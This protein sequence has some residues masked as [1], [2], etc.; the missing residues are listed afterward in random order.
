[1]QAHFMRFLRHAMA[2]SVFVAA[3]SIAGI[4]HAAPYAAMVMD[5][6]NGEVIFARNHDTKLHP[7]SLTKMMTLYVAFEAIK[8]GEVTLDSQFTVSRNATQTSCVCLGLRPG[9]QISLRYLIRAAALRSAN[10]ASVVIAEGIS[11]SVEAFAERMTRTARAMGMANT[12]FRNPHG[13]TQTGHLSTARD[14]TILGRQLYF[15]YPQYFNIF[16]RRSDFAGVGNVPNT[17][18]RFLDAYSGADG[19]KTGYTR[20]AGF[21][22][23]ASAKRGGKHIISTMFGGSSAAARNAHV[24]ELMDIGF[25]RAATRVATRAPGTPAYQG[26]AA[27]AVAQ[28]PARNGDDDPGAA[29]K[30]I[31]LQTAVRVSQRPQQRPVRAP[32]DAILLAVRESVDAAVTD[33]TTIAE[34]EAVA[35]EVG[36][37]EIAVL[38]PDALGVTPPPRPDLSEADD[39]A[40]VSLDAAV[41]AGFSIAAPEDVAELASNDGPASEES[42]AS[43]DLAPETA[44]EE[45]VQMA[46]LA[47]NPTQERAPEPEQ[48]AESVQLA[49]AQG[50]P[51]DAIELVEDSEITWIGASESLLAE[52]ESDD[53]L[54]EGLEEPVQFASL[55]QNAAPPASSGIILTSTPL[56][57]AKDASPQALAAAID[58]NLD[59]TADNNAPEVIARLS[60]SDGGRLWGVS[61][62]QFTSRHAAERSLITVKM[63]EAAALGNGVSRIRQ[64]SGRFEATV[65]GLTQ[66]EAERACLRLSARSMDC[67]ISHP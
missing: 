22:L 32:D 8:H 64:T 44:T 40:E 63:A 35:A 46:E 42:T 60:T 62:G 30:T 7:A 53:V 17:N 16:S 29:A 28:A 59:S 24:A 25:T 39:P 65:A 51:E 13:L 57:S 38:A 48:G 43:A 52:A 61:L 54:L 14:M 12:T 5:A 58:A 36:T 26:R 47:E 34:A 11:G 4:S 10:D 37:T 56:T 6:R 3:I 33:V 21:N 27:V 49:D 2:V 9:Q 15:D 66:T 50:T 18:R 19:I 41:A 1:M 55:D 23:T 67:D 31:R 45:A 20:A